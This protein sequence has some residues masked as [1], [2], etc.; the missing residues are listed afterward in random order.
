[1]EADSRSGVPHI[2][3]VI[4]DGESEDPA[5]T[6][7]QARLCRDAGITMFAV[8]VGNA[9]ESELRKIASSDD[10]VF[11]VDNFRML[12]ELKE[13]LSWKACASKQLYLL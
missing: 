5:K 8:G 2:A 11:Y 1:M 10:F 9:E 13:K 12:D 6:A 7:Q 4:T 3:I